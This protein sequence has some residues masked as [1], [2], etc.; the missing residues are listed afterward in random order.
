MIEGASAA[1]L[2]GEPDGNTLIQE[3]GKR[4]RLSHAIVERHL[5]SP[6]FF[7]LLQQF[8]NFGMDGKSFGISRQPHGELVQVL[9]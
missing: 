5:P 2:A 1:V 6:H 8:L 7:A 3:R 9:F 4:Q